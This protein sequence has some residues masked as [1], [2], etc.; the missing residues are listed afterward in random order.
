MKNL[1][2]ALLFCLWTF[3]ADSCFGDFIIV[4]STSTLLATSSGNT[5]FTKERVITD[6]SA[7]EPGLEHE[8]TYYSNA[9]IGE[10]NTSDLTKNHIDYFFQDPTA[11]LVER[12]SFWN[13]TDV[14]SVFLL[15]GAHEDTSLDASVWNRNSG[16]KDFKL[17]RSENGGSNWVEIGSFSLS[18]TLNTDL[19]NDSTYGNLYFAREQQIQFVT[20]FLANAVKVEFLSNYGNGNKIGL[21]DVNFFSSSAVPEP[22]SLF[23]LGGSTILV[24]A[25]KRLRRKRKPHNQ[26]GT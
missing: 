25:Y 22:T 18:Q 2:F 12:I 21:A 20:P 7:T 1:F 3:G 26:V 4:N 10:L 17:H 11:Q 8:E 24:G 23:L 15:G 13:I 6:L 5:N 9:W 14:S 19:Y 16:L